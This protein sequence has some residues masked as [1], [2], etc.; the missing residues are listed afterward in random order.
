MQVYE[1]F[2]C[3]ISHQT[4]ILILLGKSTFNITTN[5]HA[6]RPFFKQLYYFFFIDVYVLI[7]Y[8]S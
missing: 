3:V 8:F 6:I 7:V 2:F 1:S 5:F 4:V